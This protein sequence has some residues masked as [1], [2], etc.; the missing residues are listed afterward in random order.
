MPGTELGRR[1]QG[2][3]GRA[4]GVCAHA[5]CLRRGGQH[6]K[7]RRQR[8][9]ASAEHT[10]GGAGHLSHS[11]SHAP[12]RWLPAPAGS[13]P[14][15]RRQRQRVRRHAAGRP[16]G[17]TVSQGTLSAQAQ[18]PQRPQTWRCASDGLAYAASTCMELTQPSRGGA[19][20]VRRQPRLSFTFHTSPA[21][22]RP[23]PPSRPSLSCAPACGLPG[24]PPSPRRLRPSPPGGPASLLP[25]LL[26]AASR[27]Q[28]PRRR[29]PRS[30]RRRS[31]RRRCCRR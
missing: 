29:P 14:Q 20:G 5:A 21:S 15:R 7:E 22:W 16:P 8:P 31:T 26:A 6:L 28:P 25:C 23:S 30:R 17:R 27:P 4:A 1:D 9:H 2:A 24:Q 19:Q 3:Q 11:H 12:C 18:W 13:A 10:S